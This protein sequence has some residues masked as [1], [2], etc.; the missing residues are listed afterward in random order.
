MHT[1]GPIKIVGF[2]G[3]IGAGKSWLTR[4][5]CSKYGYAPVSFASSLKEDLLNMGF[6]YG[7]LYVEKPEP[8]RKLMQV[9]GQAR[10]YQDPNYWLHRGMGQAQAL[11]AM[12]PGVVVVFDDVRF[13]NEADAI[14]DAGGVIIRVV[15]LDNPN[16]PS[17][18]VSEIEMDTYPY[19]GLISAGSGQLEH[20]LLKAEEQLEILGVKP[21]DS[22]S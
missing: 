13:I 2:S 22:K 17:K 1:G 14:R 11:Q 15:R 3:K 8:I 19:D 4:Q 9:Y 20:L 21:W 18:D 7:D 10:R 5:L 6:S 16:P 12:I